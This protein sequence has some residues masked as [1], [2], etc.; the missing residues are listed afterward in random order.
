M[1][2]TRKAIPRKPLSVL[3]PFHQIHFDGHEKI[4]AMALDMD[5]GVGLSIYGGRC[6]YT[7]RV[8]ML[9]LAPNVRCSKTI[10]HLYL[11]WII[12]EGFGKSYPPNVARSL[13]HL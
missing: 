3:G 6:A 12:S 7:S 1:A 2:R 9:T 4:S 8:V 5:E 11:D 10:G 13:T